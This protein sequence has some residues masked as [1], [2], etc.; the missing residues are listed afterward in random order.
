MGL[1]VR[2]VKSTEF[3]I[4]IPKQCIEFRSILSKRRE[5]TEVTTELPVAPGRSCKLRDAFVILCIENYQKYVVF[6]VLYEVNHSFP[7]VMC[8]VCMILFIAE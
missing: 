7:L 6:V 5:E 4:S 3:K 1:T 8:A 2:R